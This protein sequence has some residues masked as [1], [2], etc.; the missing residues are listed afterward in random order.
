MPILGV[1]TTVTMPMLI[2][3]SIDENIDET[4]KEQEGLEAVDVGKL[5]DLSQAL[6]CVC[7]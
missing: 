6:A 3:T 7:E 2:L 4:R 1:L 5:F